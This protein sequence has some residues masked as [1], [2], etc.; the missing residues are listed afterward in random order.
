MRPSF[1]FI[2]A[3]V[4][5][6]AP[7]L[8]G[9]ATVQ[10]AMH[11]GLVSVIARDATLGEILD[12]WGRV[13]Q[14]TIINA[15]KVVGAPLTVQFADVPE[16]RAL[17]VLLRSIGGYLAVARSVARPGASRFD[18]I[19]VLPASV[20]ESPTVRQVAPT[21]SPPVLPPR[22]MMENGVAPAIGQD[23]LQAEDDRQDAPPAPAPTPS[24]SQNRLAGAPP[25]T[26]GSPAPG[27]VMMPTLQDPP[28]M[29]RRR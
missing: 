1:L 5:A 12:A 10:V 3:L 19:I 24:S 9:S 16:E 22:Q 28:S 2:A 6:A 7:P 11:D 21:L 23:G 8:A 15:E 26:L 13:G 17:D 18:R 14:T 4:I 20:W 25:S 27:I 29:P